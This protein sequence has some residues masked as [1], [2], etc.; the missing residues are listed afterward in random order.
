MA[1]TSNRVP[2]APDSGAAGLRAM[3]I[4]PSDYIYRSILRF[5]PLDRTPETW[6]PLIKYITH[7]VTVTTFKFRVECNSS[8]NVIGVL[9]YFFIFAFQSAQIGSATS[10]FPHPIPSLS[11]VYTTRIRIPSG[12]L[13]PRLLPRIPTDHISTYFHDRIFVIF[14][15]NTSKPSPFLPFRFIGHVRYSIHSL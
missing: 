15:L 7:N 14:S 8:V 11:L 1:A 5:N 10:V 4:D 6:V 12:K 13:H 2:R 3:T 9:F